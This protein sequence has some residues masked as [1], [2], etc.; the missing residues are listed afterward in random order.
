MRQ[1]HVEA[2]PLRAVPPHQ[3]DLVCGRRRELTGAANCRM[4]VSQS[5]QC[6]QS[7]HDRP[8]Q[9]LLQFRRGVVVAID[10]TTDATLEKTFKITERVKFDVRGEFYN[11]LNH[12]NFN[13]PG[14]T[15]GAADFGVVSS[16]RP[17]RTTQIA[18][19]LSF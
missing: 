15:F 13:I 14:F 10:V 17:G 16:S 6:E 1:V 19:R 4:R 11:L 9:V 2:G 8:V 3:H 5:Q 7:L 18:L 12:A